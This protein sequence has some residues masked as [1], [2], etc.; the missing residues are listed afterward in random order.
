MTR[1]MSLSIK[2]LFTFV[3]LFILAVSGSYFL[4]ALSS[5]DLMLE[6]AREASLQKAHIV[7]EAIVY[8]MVENDKVEDTFLN[9]LQTV[10]GLRDLYVRIRPDN[11]R[12]T[13][14]FDDDTTRPRRLKMR[15]ESALAKGSIGEEVFDTG[16]P[17]WVV[18]GDDVEAIIP[19]KAEKKCQQ[20]HDVPLNHVLGVAHVQIPLANIQ[21]SI[22]ANANRMAMISSGFAV[23]VILI[24]FFLYRSFIQTPVKKLVEA[25]EAIGQGNMSVSMDVSASK[26]E[27]GSLSRSID[28]MRTALKQSQDALRTSTVGQI[29]QTMIRDFRAPVRQI[30]QAVSAIEKPDTDSSL[31]SELAAQARAAVETMNKM[32]QDLID[33]TTGEMKANKMASS[34]PGLVQ[35][36]R[37]SVKTELEKESIR[38]EVREGFSG[39]A[40]LDYERIGRALV[41][42][43]NYS[44]NYVPPGGQITLSTESDRKNVIFRI[45]NDG[46][47]IPQQFLGRIFEPF[48]KVVQEKGLGLNL[49]LA[50][51]IVEL[52]G[53]KIDVVSLETGTTFTLQLPLT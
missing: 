34:V 40:Q 45:R 50:K 24:G 38:F 42:I 17:L 12:L 44:A 5:Q 26:D 37:E 10:G 51:R 18:H 27:L 11:L 15:M 8:Q 41:N 36:V 43:I 29:A 20:C 33:F 23:V 21:G 2:L 39:N 13:E 4:N 53:G 31:R 9:R 47:P 30:L 28:R 7:R 1:G 6:Q 25:T 3:P 14:E 49:A 16:V 52:Q 35:Y 19:F 48:V 32:T 22:N 46:S